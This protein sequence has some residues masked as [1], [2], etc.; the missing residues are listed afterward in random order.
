MENVA[1]RPHPAVLRTGLQNELG[2]NR[3]EAQSWSSEGGDAADLYQRLQRSGVE[4]LWDDR[5]VSAV[6]KLAGA[7][8]IGLPQRIVVSSQTRK[9]GK[10]EVKS[11]IGEP[12]L[13]AVDIAVAELSSAQ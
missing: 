1:L 11:R 8:L 13:K 3:S 6:L 12:E 5:D 9:Q 10:I 2:S 7:G 4:D